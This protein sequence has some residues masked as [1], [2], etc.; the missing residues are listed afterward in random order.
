MLAT[1][2]TLPT[3]QDLNGSSVHCVKQEQVGERYE[4]SSIQTPVK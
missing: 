4:T 2:T 3:L 1:F